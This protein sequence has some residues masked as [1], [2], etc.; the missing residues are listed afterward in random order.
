[1]FSSCFKYYSL[2]LSSKHTVLF[3]TSFSRMVSE[4]H[5]QLTELCELFKLVETFQPFFWLK[6]CGFLSWRNDPTKLWG[7][8]QHLI[9]AIY[10]DLE[11]WVKQNCYWAAWKYFKLNI[12]NWKSLE[13]NL[14]VFS[15][16]S[17]ERAVSCNAVMFR[18]CC[19]YF[20]LYIGYVAQKTPCS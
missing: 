10:Q 6:F 9:P 17:G 5:V 20:S 18:F 13:S 12:L 2:P 15:E 3:T 8:L 4:L 16:V 1:M 7:G 19:L 14:M 11:V